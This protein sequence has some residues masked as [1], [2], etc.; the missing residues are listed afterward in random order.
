MSLMAVYAMPA[1]RNVA[2]V[3]YTVSH[4]TMI[5]N[6]SQSFVR[7]MMGYVQRGH[8]SDPINFWSKIVTLDRGESETLPL[9]D[10]DLLRFSIYGAPDSQTSALHHTS[11]DYS[12]RDAS[13]IGL[14]IG[15]YKEFTNQ[16]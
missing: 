15:Y 9:T 14:S 1:P 4:I 13:A 12:V 3:D 5:N 6:S 10:G 8:D 7:Y 2:T 11:L 16:Y